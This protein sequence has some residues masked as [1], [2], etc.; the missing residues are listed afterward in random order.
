MREHERL[1]FCGEARRRQRHDDSLYI[2]VDAPH[3]SPNRVNLEI[4]D[5]SRQLAEG[6]PEEFTDMLEIAAYVYCAD[7]FTNRGSNKMSNMGSDWRRRFRFRIP[8]RKPSLWNKT[9]ISEALCETLG[10]LAEDEFSFEFVP[11]TN[12]RP[13]QAYLPFGDSGAQRLDEVVLFSGG[14]DS[15][16][17][18]VDLLFGSHRRVAL[19]SHQSSTMIAS[20]QNRLVQEL[21][22]RTASGSLIH[23]PIRVNKGSEEATEFTQRTRS[24]LFASLGFVAARML[25]LNRLRFYENGVVS[26]N[27]PIAEHVLGAR[28]SRTTHPRFLADCGRLFSLLLGAE[29][30]IQNPFI[31]KTKAEVIRGLTGLGH[32]DLVSSTMSCTRV[33]EI[34]KTGKHCGGCSQCVDRRVST[35]AANANASDPGSNY[36]VDL[37]TGAQDDSLALATIETYVVRA[38]KLSTM[39]Q[40]AFL[41]TYGQVFRAAGYIPGGVDDAVKEI[42][43]LHQRHGAEVVSVIDDQLAKAASLEK[44]S[45][46]PVNSLLAMVMSPLGVQRRY[47]DP[48]ET[49]PSAATQA[50]QDTYEH[51]PDRL[52]IALDVNGAKVVI[53]E[54]I[55]LGKGVFAIMSALRKEYEVDRDAG[56]SPDGYRYVQSRTFAE[57][58]GVAEDSM[59]MKV[60]RARRSIEQGFQRQRGRTIDGHDIIQNREW[61]GY[62]LSPY[63]SLVLVASK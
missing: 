18:A 54:S 28:A 44:L 46:L 9:E 33:R 29:F 5:L 25:R 56:T 26:I 10:F 60:L 55:V 62:R 42:W 57:R 27:L 47:T 13:L 15:L 4:G 58:L 17:G 32:G 52:I 12:P 40:K 8:V 49:E 39:S 21:R 50:E 63:L 41:A 59:R 20:K 35:L 7:Q 24:M 19:V 2:D 43:R 30:T 48:V 22:L 11:A 3:D 61:K 23:V 45:K 1:V 38:Q 31:L 51:E 34:T 53:N 14:L 16:A 36:S 37:F 6:M